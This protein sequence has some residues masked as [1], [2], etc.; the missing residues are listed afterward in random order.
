MSK[1]KI[2]VA[3]KW[4]TRLER[5]WTD[6]YSFHHLH[7]LV[8]ADKRTLEEIARDTLKLLNDVEREFFGFTPT[9]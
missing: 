1:A 6:R 8:E 9:S 4:R 3:R 7:P 2:A 5:M